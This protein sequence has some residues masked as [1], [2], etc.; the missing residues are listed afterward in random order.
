MDANTILSERMR[1]LDEMPEELQ[2]VAQLIDKNDTMTL[3]GGLKLKH[4]AGVRLMEVKN[5]PTTYGFDSSE[6]LAAYFNC[7]LDYLYK[8]AKFAETYSEEE[9]TETA[10]LVVEHSAHVTYSHLS[11]IA[12]VD[13]PKRRR[14]LLDQLLA[15]RQSVRQLRAVIAAENP[16]RKLG[17]GRKPKR[18]TSLPA[19]LQSMVK[20]TTGYRKKME[21]LGEDL[22]DRIDELSPAECTD[23]LTADIREFLKGCQNV[24]ERAE[25]HRQRAEGFQERRKKIMNSQPKLE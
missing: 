7:S 23:T 21:V 25:H 8:L 9:I 19:A 24:I 6:K 5:N 4:R 13:S 17:G 22:F 2:E 11:E 3:K 14:E 18:F 15:Q 10:K 20:V 12:T 1:L 16:K